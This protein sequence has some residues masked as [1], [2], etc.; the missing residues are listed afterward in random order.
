MASSGEGVA[1]PAEL[2]LVEAARDGD[3][4]AFAELYRRFEP[5][6]RRSAARAAARTPQLDVDDAVNLAMT[7]LWTALPSFDTTREFTPWAAVVIAHAVR[8]AARTSRSLRSSWNW[9]AMLGRPRDEEVPGSPLERVAAPPEEG[10]LQQLLLGEEE[11]LVAHA[12]QEVLSSREAEVMRLRLAGWGY[13]EIEARTGLDQKAVDNALHRARGKLRE[14][15]VRRE[16][17]P[18]AKV[19]RS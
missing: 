13:A 10:G 5:V 6:A 18:G 9:N 3:H 15:F 14:A 11:R 1:D 19:G 4:E 12:L 2:A 7:R 8:S 16:D 17:A